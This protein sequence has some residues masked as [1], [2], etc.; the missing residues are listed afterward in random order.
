MILSIYYL[1]YSKSKIKVML[2]EDNQIIFKDMIK[3][4]FYDIFF[5]K[6]LHN[7]IYMTGLSHLL[8]MREKYSF[9]N[10]F[11]DVDYKI[12]SQNGEDG[13]IDYLLSQL[14][15][16]KPKFVEIGVGD[17]TEANTR[18]VF[19]RTSAKGVIIDCIYGLEKKI[20]KNLATWRGELNVI[21]RSVNSKN[22]IEILSTFD[23][24][25]DLDLFSID[26]DGIDYWILNK[27]PKNF[28]KIA[29]IEYNPIFGKD[30]EVSVPNI[31][32]FNR[33]KYHYSNLCFG[34]SLKAAIK[35]M[36]SKNFY[37]LGTNLFRNNAFFVS[38]DFKKNKYFSNLKINE[39]EKYVDSNFSES[40]NKNGKLNFL[41]KKKQIM[42][43]LDCEIVDLSQD[44]FIKKKLKEIID[45]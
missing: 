30:I 26:I 4:N 14:S 9:V 18:F 29:I 24:L 22:I 11:S 16:E 40:R 12:F 19:E 44:K 34:M 32:N 17:Y 31:D 13:I 20:S 38:N 42:E 37:F 27:L 23:S 7:K 43:I 45:I 15:I 25:R 41:N 39:L 35:I 2:Y 21:N 33:T 6:F 5:K 10:S 1:K 8:N 36:Q 3:K 28:S